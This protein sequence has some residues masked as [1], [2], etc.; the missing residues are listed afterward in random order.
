M[1][2]SSSAAMCKALSSQSVLM[3]NSHEISGY[4]SFFSMC[5]AG[6]TQGPFKD[7]LVKLKHAQKTHKTAHFLHKNAIVVKDLCR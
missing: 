4:F 7:Q 5:F 2:A 1:F 6:V 3:Q